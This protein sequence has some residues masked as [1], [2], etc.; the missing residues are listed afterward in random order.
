[1]TQ[2]RI[3]VAEARQMLLA[4]MGDALPPATQ[5]VALAQA[6]A[7]GR[8][9]AS[10]IKAPL[11]I[12]EADISAMDGVA[13]TAQQAG[14]KQPLR[15]V[16]KSLA[17]HPCKTPVATGEAVEIATGAWLPEGCD[18]VMPIEACRFDHQQVW[19][20]QLPQVGRNVRRRAEV[21]ARGAVVISAGERLDFRH[22]A[23]LAALGIE[24]V[25]VTRPLR[26]ALFSSGDELSGSSA[27]G[28]QQARFD[29][30]SP[31]LAALLQCWGVEVS[32]CG[33]LEDSPAAIAERLDAA[34]QHAD[35]LITSGGISRGPHDYVR[36]VLAE[37]GIVPQRMAHKPGQALAFGRWQQVPLIALPGNPL[38]ALGCCVQLVRPAL[39]HLSGTADPMPTLAATLAAPVSGRAGRSELLLARYWANEEGR[40][41]AL[42]LAKQ[43]SHQLDALLQASCLIELDEHTSRLS[44]GERVVIHPLVALSG[45]N[46]GQ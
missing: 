45:G 38:A 37:H 8:C 17:G 19:L 3:S 31:M 41:Y 11:D 24:Q 33:V 43:N 40:L 32:V 23:M 2:P 10:D 6:Q 7:V 22:I 26:I 14:T 18:S 28:S 12:P 21:V 25:E 16:G 9:L 42:P 36:D 30:N 35:M 1:M 44:K 39:T 13:F 5:R 15:I 46:H 34:A 29:A 20:E 27:S 4:A